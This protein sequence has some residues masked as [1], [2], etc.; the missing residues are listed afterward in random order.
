MLNQGCV[1]FTTVNIS[2][3]T[4]LTTARTV[5]GG[6]TQQG[7]RAQ[8]EVLGKELLAWALTLCGFTAFDSCHL[9]SLSPQASLTWLSC[10][11]AARVGIN[12]WLFGLVKWW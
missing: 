9:L 5:A 7:C 11:L 10:F 2:L 6:E 1:F 4:A 3:D 12:P 8:E